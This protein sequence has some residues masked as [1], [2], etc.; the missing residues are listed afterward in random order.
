MN[1]SSRAHFCL[2]TWMKSVRLVLAPWWNQRCRTRPEKRHF[3]G[4]RSKSG[5][6]TISFIISFQLS[7]SV[8]LSFLCRPTKSVKENLKKRKR[9]FEQKRHKNSKVEFSNRKKALLI[10][11]YPSVW[12]TVKPLLSGHPREWANWPLNRGWPLNGGFPKCS[13]IYGKNGTVRR[14][15]YIVPIHNNSNTK[16]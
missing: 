9:D 13:T 14:I 7:M 3:E 1:S 6:N 5:I 15:Q 10:T 16:Y 8:Y 12:N 2:I 4:L 11:G